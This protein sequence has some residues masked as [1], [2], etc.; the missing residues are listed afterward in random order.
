M[1]NNRF[2]PFALWFI[3]TLTALQGFAQNYAKTDSLVKGFGAMTDKNVAQIAQ[4]I[5]I[6]FPE[7]IQKARAVFY[8]IA[9][10]I[11][12]DPKATKSYDQKNSDPVKVIELRKATPLGFSLLFQEMC[13]QAD[14]RCLSVDGYTKSFADEINDQPDEI[15][16]SWNVVQLGQSKDEWFYV[17]VAKAA[18]YLDKKQSL[19]TPEF[20]SAYFFT[21]KILFNLSHYPDNGAWLLGPGPK[22]LKDFYALPVFGAAAFELGVQKPMPASGLL[23]S[24]LNGKIDFTIPYNEKKNITKLEIVAGDER[25]NPKPVLVKFSSAEGGMQFTYNC[26]TEAEFPL[27][28]LADGRE[29]LVYQLLVEE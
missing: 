10:N 22:S 8:W 5:T 25:K 13:S 4:T 27:K 2:K 1:K 20:C 29:I 15:N 3:F 21:N 9:H 7:K 26:K 28:I 16:H 18:G 17:D 23:K 24:K 6:S 19:F 12:I 14:I 11:A